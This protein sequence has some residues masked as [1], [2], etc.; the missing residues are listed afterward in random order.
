MGVASEWSMRDSAINVFACPDG[1]H[2][3]EFGEIFVEEDGEIR[4]GTLVDRKHHRVWPV[5]NFIPRFVRNGSY[6]ESFG[7]QWNRYRRTQID[8]FNGTTLSRDR[9]YEG[10]GWSPDDLK[11][12]RILEVGGSLR[13]GLQYRR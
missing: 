9:F 5:H 7:E 2:S 6:A 8:R 1:G 12:Q 13:Y 3:L 10:T 4:E 11:G